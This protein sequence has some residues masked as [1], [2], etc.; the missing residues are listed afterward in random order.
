MT[1]FNE[2]CAL[3]GV[4]DDD[5]VRVRK[6]GELVT[7][8]MDEFIECLYRFFKETL[9]ADYQVHFPDSDT[10]ARAQSAARR[11]WFEF[12]KGEWNDEYI[13]SRERIGKTHAQ[14]QIE[15]RHYLA[16]MNKALDLWTDEL[17]AGEGLDPEE[18]SS[19]T[20]SVRR[21]IQMEGAMVVDIYARRTGEVIAQQSRAMIDMSAPI[22]AIWDD[23]LMLPIVGILDSQR[24]E[25]VM[26]RMLEKIA[27]KQATMF[28]LDISGVAVVDTAVADHLIRMTKAARLM[29]CET[30]VSGLSPSVARTIVELGIE[31]GDVKTTGNL[32][33]ALGIAFRKGGPEG[34]IERR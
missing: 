3:F 29:G 19:I 13:S 34:R 6:L 20:T 24:A 11:A 9:G 2:M 31:I 4:D 8:K 28:I 22:A 33:D 10:V 25:D 16:A 30:I 14:L 12:F 17:C 18:W 32:Q 26:Q 1:N 5:L 21:V 27:E 23:V 15:P 7:P